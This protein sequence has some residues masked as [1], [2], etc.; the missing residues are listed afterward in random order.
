MVLIR[1][2][3]KIGIVDTLVGTRNLVVEVFRVSDVSDVSDTHLGSIAIRNG[4]HQP[5]LGVLC[6]SPFLDKPTANIS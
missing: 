4:D 3:Q 1:V 5:D 2:D 6:G